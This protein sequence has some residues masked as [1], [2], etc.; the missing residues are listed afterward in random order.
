MREFLG[1]KKVMQRMREI[2]GRQLGSIVRRKEAS[3]AP[4]T[5]CLNDVCPST[6]TT[7]GWQFTGSAFTIEI[8]K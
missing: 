3:E 7:V 8:R 5:L 4:F 1:L 6:A 2:C